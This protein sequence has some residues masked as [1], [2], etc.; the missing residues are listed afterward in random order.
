MLTTFTGAVWPQ[1]LSL[2]NDMSVMVADNGVHR[3]LQ[4]NADDLHRDRVITD[5]NS[6]VKF[7]LPRRVC[8]NELTSQLYVVHHSNEW[9]WSDTVSVLSLQ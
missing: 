2:I 5:S 7:W 8:Y 9:S 1:H 6:D 4:L 3:L